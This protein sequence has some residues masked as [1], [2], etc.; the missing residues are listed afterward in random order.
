MK[1]EKPLVEIKGFGGALGLLIDNLALFDQVED[2]LK[3]LLKRTNS[4]DF[5]QGAEIFLQ[6]DQHKFTSDEFDRLKTILE[7]DGDL[8]LKTMVAE[9]VTSDLEPDLLSQENDSD[10][11]LSPEIAANAL[12]QKRSIGASIATETM[13]HLSEIPP[14]LEYSASQQKS[15]AIE[16][17]SAPENFTP[18]QKLPLQE[19]ISVISD[20]ML[21]DQAPANQ[22]LKFS[23]KQLDKNPETPDTEGEEPVI[24]A[25]LRENSEQEDATGDL[26]PET[27]ESS[28]EEL[29]SIP[30]LKTGKSLLVRQTLHSGQSVRSKISVLLMG[31][32]NA[33]AEIVSDQDVFV[34]G[35][36][37]GMVHAGASGNR[38]SRVFGLRMQP[39]QI[40]IAELITQPSSEDKKTP[41]LVPEVAF[42]EDEYIYIETCWKFRV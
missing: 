4:K 19:P 30:N 38:D 16:Q 27:S 34:L 35:S 36:I 10:Q 11:S 6:G 40:R 1:L 14:G 23:E 12:A 33:G 3:K 32:L 28:L 25:V 8:H 39:T 24:E 18:S 15:Q 22:N 13:W 5:F 21:M 9:K 37:R 31:D 2:E 26:V 42:I 7:C 17:T 41:Q 29:F 20:T